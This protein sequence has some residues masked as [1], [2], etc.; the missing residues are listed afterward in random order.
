MFA[1]LDARDPAQRDRALS[2]SLSL[3][4]EAAAVAALIVAPLLYTTALPNL[5]RDYIVNAP[6][7]L[8]SVEIAHRLAACGRRQRAALAHRAAHSA[9]NSAGCVPRRR[10]LSGAG[11]AALQ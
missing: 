10:W 7:R 6:Q 9:R 5:H 11:S 4:A 2:I 1:L 8:G 3:G